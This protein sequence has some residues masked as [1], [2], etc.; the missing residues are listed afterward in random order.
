[1]QERTFSLLTRGR[2]ALAV[3]WAVAFVVAVG[4]RVPTTATE[5][6]AAIALLL[7]A[8][9]LIDAVSSFVERRWVNGALS[10]LAAVALA[11]TGF[12]GDARDALLVFGAWAAV[13]GALQLALALR[14]RDG[15]PMIVSGG[16]S[17][18]AG[19]SFVAASSREEAQ[20]AMLAG[21][22]AVGAVLYLVSTFRARRAVAVA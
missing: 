18:L 10:T 9:P 21:Y 2:A 3:V 7:A 17:T 19:V 15:W 4:D 13:S 22:A 20:L 1:M 14:H 16:L 5:L 6:T 11:V 12:A 8:Y